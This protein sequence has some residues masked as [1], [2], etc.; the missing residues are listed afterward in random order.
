MKRSLIALAVLGA[1][2]GA[3]SAQSSVTIYGSIDLAVTKSN[4]GTAFNQGVSNAAGVNS[5]AWQLKQ[6]NASR[7]GFRGNEDLGGG[8]S[9]QFDIQHR[10]TPDDG[11][12]NA[13]FWAGRSTVSLTSTTAGR[14]YLGRDYTPSYYVA[15]KSDPFGQ[16]GIAQVGGRQFA[17]FSAQGGNPRAPA[18]RT[19]NTVGY[20]SPSLGGFTVQAAVAAGE[21][22]TGRQA[23]FNAEYTQ[24]PIYAGLGYEKIS[25]GPLATAASPSGDGS[26]L[27]NVAFH[28]NF[29]P[30]KPILY[31]ARSKTGPG[32]NTTAK[33]AE[34]GATAPI[35]AGK[36]KAAYSRYEPD[37]DN[38]TENKLGLGY[39]YFLS[40]RTNVYGDASFAKQD[41]KTNSRA[42]ALGVKHVF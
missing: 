20:N 34:V 42:F 15:L 14:V 37:G 16:D 5:S 32:A 26:S 4:D 1:F 8:L 30:I 11:V 13:T 27:I 35:G 23:G 36:F 22:T 9:A 6:S 25:G 18:I 24:G 12:A 33:F 21:G 7:L 40:K 41:T 3:A 28:Y 38:N 10:Y 31:Y 39:D 17:G 19:N 29:G 2:A